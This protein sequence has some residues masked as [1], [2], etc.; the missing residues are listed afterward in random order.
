[1]GKRIRII[2]PKVTMQAVLNGSETAEKV[3]GILPC[4]SKARLYGDEV[5]FEVPLEMGEEDAQPQVPSGTIAYW[6]PG[7]CL[8]IFF[9]QTPASPVNVVGVLD[10]DPQEWAAVEASDEI[11][12]EQA[13][14]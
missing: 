13:E 8:C 6:P 12:V 11:T 7:K 3:W 1:M 4:D 9:G 10:G 2:S 5:Y 14:E